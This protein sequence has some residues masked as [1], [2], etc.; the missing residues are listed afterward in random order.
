[1]VFVTGVCVTCPLQRG[2]CGV[3]DRCQCD[4]SIREVCMWCL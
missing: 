4:T 2:V 3:Y 1:M